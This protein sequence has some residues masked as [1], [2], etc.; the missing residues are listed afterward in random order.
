MSTLHATLEA[1]HRESAAQP[2]NRTA[3]QQVN[4]LVQIGELLNTTQVSPPELQQ[5]MEQLKA[6]APVAVAPPQVPAF[7]PVQPQL[8][9]VRPQVPNFPPAP[10]S[11]YHDP[12]SVPAR[13]SQISPFPNLPPAAASTPMA[14]PSTPIPST[15]S[16]PAQTTSSLSGIPANVADILRNLNTSGIISNPRTPEAKV[17]KLEAKSMLETY[18]EMMISLDIRLESLD[19]KQ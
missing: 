17:A 6:M 1:K 12:Y 19:L 15:Q 10:P 13:P 9:I 5:I 7:A 4:V 18:E 11:F 16:Q 8:P 3:A 2:W 14:H